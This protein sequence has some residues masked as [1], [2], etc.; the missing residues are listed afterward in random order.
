MLLIFRK[1]SVGNVSA[2]LSALFFASLTVFPGSYALAAML[3][4]V[5][6]LFMLPKTWRAF[7]HKEVRIISLALCG[8]FIAYLLEMLIHH[9]SSSTIDMPNRVLLATLALAL[10]YTYPPRF[11]W[12]LYAIMT[13]AIISGC[14]ALYFVFGLDDRAFYDHGYMVIQIGGI[15]AALG[16]LSLICFFYT[17]Q[18]HQGSKLVVLTATA[19]L[20]AFMATLLSGARGSWVLTPFIIILVIWYYRQHISHKG[21]LLGSLCVLIV[22]SVAAPQIKMRVGAAVSDI[23]QYQQNDSTSNSG[24]RLEMWR[25]ALYT[26]KKYPLLGAGHQEQLLQEKKH[27]IAEGLINPGI[28]KFTRAHNQYLEELQ[29]K[30]IMGVFFLLLLFGIPLRFFYKKSQ[31]AQKLAQPQLRA[32]SIMGLSYILM[33]MGFCLT[34]HYLN[35]HSGI[36][37]F[38]FGVVILAAQVMALENKIKEAK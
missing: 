14:L 20:F 22:L 36:L 5:L 17:L 10:L 18:Q 1:L 26:A 28:L 7:K 9:E 34:Q 31:L 32:A 25:S 6:A 8:Y 11:K 2:F 24:F 16:I 15:C 23:D 38:T 21:L 4:S 30:G 13:G 33:V 37:M 27:Q 35:H 19:T 29:T 12:I 3:L